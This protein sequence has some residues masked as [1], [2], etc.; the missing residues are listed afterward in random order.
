[1]M[2]DKEAAAV[3][4]IMV[5]EEA[6]KGVATTRGAVETPGEMETTSIQTR[7]QQSIGMD[8]RDSGSSIYKCGGS[9][10]AIG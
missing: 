1:M 7:V 5:E 9:R 2:R 6:E 3:V 8:R 4:P 10:R